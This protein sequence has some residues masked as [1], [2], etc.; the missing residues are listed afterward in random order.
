MVSTLARTE[1]HGRRSPQLLSAPQSRALA[2]CVSSRG[3]QSCRL[4]LRDCDRVC[5]SCDGYESWGMDQRRKTISF[6]RRAHWATPSSQCQGET[7]QVL[8][9]VLTRL[10][11]VGVDSHPAE[12]E[13][14]PPGTALLA[15]SH[16]ARSQGLSSESNGQSSC[17]RP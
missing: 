13:P 17:G 12:S 9:C 8:A 2:Q 4:Y 1:S 11:G 3:E 10:P 6:A 16:R 7:P 15:S 5:R 14:C